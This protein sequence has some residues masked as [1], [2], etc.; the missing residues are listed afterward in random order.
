MTCFAVRGKA[1]A[2]VGP[3]HQESEVDLIARKDSRKDSNSR[4]TLN[5]FVF[6]LTMVKTKS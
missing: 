4:L 5:E 2:S 6:D 3:I 1:S